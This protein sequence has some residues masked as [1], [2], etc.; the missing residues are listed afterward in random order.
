MIYNKTQIRNLINLNPDLKRQFVQNKA[1]AYLDVLP[2]S[3]GAGDGF[4]ISYNDYLKDFELKDYK[5]VDDKGVIGQAVAKFV[6]GN[7]INV[8]ADF[9]IEN[10]E[11]NLYCGII[12]DDNEELYINFG[13]Y[14]VQ[15]P[16]NEEVTT[17]TKFEAYDYMIKFNQ[18]YVDNMTYPCTIYDLYV[19]VCNQ[20]G[21]GYSSAAFRNSTKIVAGN[22]FQEGETLR[23]VIKAIAG[24]AF[25]WARIDE[26]NVCKLDFDIIENPTEELTDD[27]YIEI[28]ANNQYGEV[29]RIILRDSQVDGENYVYPLEPPEGKQIAIVV[30]DNPFAYTQA[31]RA[32]LIVAGGQLL[33]LKY[34]PIKASLTGRI[35][36]DCT[37][38]I[39][40][41]SM[42]PNLYGKT[43]GEVNSGTVA[44]LLD[45]EINKLT[46]NYYYSTYV[47]DHTIK[48]DGTIMDDF[49]TPAMTDVEVAYQFTSEMVSEMKKTEL[50][51]D[52]INGEIRSEVE[53][54]KETSDDNSILISNLTQ[55]VGELESKIHNETD[56][57]TTIK[58]FGVNEAEGINTGE[59][60]RLNVRP[61][62]GTD[63]V[64]LYPS[65]GLYPHSRE[66][67]IEQINPEQGVTPI[68]LEY[69]IPQDLYWLN[70]E[71]YDEFWLDYKSQQ[72]YVIKRVQAT[73]DSQGNLTKTAMPLEEK[74]YYD[75]PSLPM[76]DGDYRFYMPAFYFAY[77]EIRLMLQNRYTDEFATR[78]ELNST[79]TQLEDRIT[80]EVTETIEY[81]DGTKQ[82]LSS[83]I[84][85]TINSISL[86]VNSGLTTTG[87][88]II[89]KRADGTKE[90]LNGIIN[91][92]GLVTFKS[93]EESD[94]TTKING[95]NITTGTINSARLD[96]SLINAITGTIG[97]IT[98]DNNGLVY[99]G[100]TRN[101]GFGLWRGNF[102]QA[103]TPAGN[104]SSI[105]FHSGG[106][107]QNI[108]GAGFRIYEDG[109]VYVEQ[110]YTA[111]TTYK[112]FVK[113][114]NVE[115]IRITDTTANPSYFE[116]GTYSGTTY[117]VTVDMSDENLKKNMEENTDIDALDIINSIK[118]YSFDWKTNDIHEELGFKAQQLQEVNEDFVYAVKQGEGSD[119]DEIL[120][121]NTFRMQPYMIKSIQ[122]LSKENKELKQKL[123]DIEERLANL[124]R[125]N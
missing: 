87:I 69:N 11:F 74:I 83:R 82:E 119:L 66:F 60:I 96:T 47:F 81:V 93:L 106:N 72:C 44:D 103:T 16:D 39:R 85:Q 107:N 37:D 105:I 52:K 121:V 27:D 124:E 43:V 71:V 2:T 73:Y 33:G 101:D 112:I 36:L 46:N 99:S 3:S 91:M 79:R 117:G 67:V 116:I 113:T 104:S 30:D 123:A 56:I 57:T 100:D 12:T 38:K 78:V 55:R 14:I 64:A 102:H 122:E 26:N 59:P 86:V 9:N 114:N 5:F 92:T 62:N 90:V 77:Y 108:G 97:N 120:Q 48:F 110:L 76:V 42:I 84:N 94:G 1:I 54:I 51:V 115:H 111:G 49:D 98:I 13:T 23:D 40:I 28:G 58:G 21:V 35:Y 45:T 61:V 32:D 31:L 10:R 118:L 29:N 80:D 95:A 53:E 41:K 88:D 34:I 15:R 8:D 20:A 68:K 17:N 65:Q 125:R 18:P 109:C 70:S 63:I 75:Y 22:L 4:Q 7:F 24:I 19:D 6:S 25:S 50:V 89:L